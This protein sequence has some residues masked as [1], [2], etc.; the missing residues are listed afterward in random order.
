MDRMTVESHFLML[1]IFKIPLRT[2]WGFA[3]SSL[4]ISVT[5]FGTSV[6]LET[7]LKTQKNS[8]REKLLNLMEILKSLWRHHLEALNPLGLLGIYV[9]TF[10]TPMLTIATTWKPLKF[11]WKPFE[12][13]WRPL[14]S[15]WKLLGSK[16][17]VLESPKEL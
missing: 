12:D 1:E 4:E 17:N 14:G 2:S 15:Y 9:N 7:R 3:Q 5:D 11:S 10:R 6:N 8:S 16:G 13:H